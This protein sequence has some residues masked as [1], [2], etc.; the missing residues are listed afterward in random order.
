[1]TWR[2]GDSGLR[3]CGPLYRDRVGRQAYRQTTSDPTRAQRRKHKRD[4]IKIASL[5]ESFQYPHSSETL[6]TPVDHHAG[7]VHHPE[8][9]NLEED[10]HASH[11]ENSSHPDSPD[12]LKLGQ[13]ETEVKPETG[14][15]ED[16]ATTEDD[17][18]WGLG[19][20]DQDDHEQRNAETEMWETQMWTTS[21]S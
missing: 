11:E 1:M 17:A 5:R 19:L 9:G 6:P 20:N 12:N 15:H 10:S 3:L 4:I 14:S 21:P 13:E 8:G 16:I 7:G 2:T 18:P